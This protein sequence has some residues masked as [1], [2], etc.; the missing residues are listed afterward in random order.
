MLLGL[1]V[2]VGRAPLASV[3]TDLSF[4]ADA[5]R[6]AMARV[7]HRNLRSPSGNLM[8]VQGFKLLSDVH[9]ER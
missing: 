1:C 6:Y 3:S 2:A 5:F 8:R 9:G 7:M 4:H